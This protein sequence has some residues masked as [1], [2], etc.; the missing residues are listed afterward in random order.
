[1]TQSLSLSSRLLNARERHRVEHLSHERYAE[2]CEHG[3]IRE[4]DPL[5]MRLRGLKTLL[6]RD[7]KFGLLAGLCEIVTGLLLFGFFRV[8]RDGIPSDVV[9]GVGFVAGLALLAWLLCWAFASRSEMIWWRVL[10]SFA[11]S[12]ISFLWS[13]RDLRL[14]RQAIKT[15]LE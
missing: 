3:L 6:S 9:I 12:P 14:V 13:Y 15:D 1:M 4:S 7:A 2:M 8:R 5:P 11:F 10:I